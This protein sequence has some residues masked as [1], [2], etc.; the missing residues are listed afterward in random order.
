MWE[1]LQTYGIWILFGI[2]FLLM[3]RMH[4]HGMHGMGGG[5]GMGMGHDQY[6]EPSDGQRVVPL[7]DKYFDA[8]RAVP[9]DE[10]ADTQRAV[11]LDAEYSDAQRRALIAGEYSDDQRRTLVREIPAEGDSVTTERYPT[12]RH[13]GC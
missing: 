3:M 1:F 4:G 13:S 7:R 6:D 11:P 8:Q 12:K 10:Y 9:L 2:L 5:C